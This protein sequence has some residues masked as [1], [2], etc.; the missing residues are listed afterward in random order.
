MDRTGIFALLLAIPLAVLANLLTPIIRNWI[1]L[2]SKKMTAQ[3]IKVL[4][5]ELVRLE[6]P[7]SIEAVFAI[8]WY[9]F[10]VL[11]SLSG[12]LAF[13][14]LA[15]MPPIW[16]WPLDVAYLLFGVATFFCVMGLVEIRKRKSTKYKEKLEGQIASLK[17]KLE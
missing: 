16:N 5:Y 14:S 9:L 11:I 3:R 17:S 1:A 4:K 10:F 13:L 6:T 15:L 8:L 2:L 7:G 12:G